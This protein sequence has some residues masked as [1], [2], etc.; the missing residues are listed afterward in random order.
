VKLE[1]NRFVILFLDASID[2]CIGT[3]IDLSENLVAGKS[4]HSSVLLIKREI[5]QLRE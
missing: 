4:N 1:D 5:E 3:F 2:K